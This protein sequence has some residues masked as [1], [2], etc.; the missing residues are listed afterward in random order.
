MQVIGR[1]MQVTD[2]NV[3]HRKEKCKSLVEKCK[4]WTKNANHRHECKSLTNDG[5]HRQKIYDIER[6]YFTVFLVDYSTRPSDHPLF[7]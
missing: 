4:S 1:K 5:S 7:T 6:I 3:R 2:K